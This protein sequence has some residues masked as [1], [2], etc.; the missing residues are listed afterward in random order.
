[1][2]ALTLESD[3]TALVL[4]DLQ[5]GIAGMATAPHAAGDVIARARELARRFREQHATVILVRVDPGRNGE[6]FPRLRTDVERP[7]MA[8]PASWSEIVPELGPEDGDIVVTK[9]QPGAFY[10][11]DLEVQLRRRGI[12][13]IVLGGISTNIGVEATARGA[14]ERGYNIVFVE[15]AMSAREADMHA[16]AVQRFFPTIG[17]VRSTQ[18]V[19]EALG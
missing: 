15:D 4:I 7:P 17:R 14:Q 8:L 13:T 19:L 5:R 11:T 3:R 9:H 18:E 12:D 6:L 10:C 2:P 1:M 16:F